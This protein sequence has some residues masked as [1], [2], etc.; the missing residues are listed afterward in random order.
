MDEDEVRKR[1]PNWK[2]P[3]EHLEIYAL[4]SIGRRPDEVRAEFEG[5]FDDI[6]GGGYRITKM[7]YDART[8]SATFIM[9]TETSI[10]Y[11][12][13]SAFISP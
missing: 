7:V 4:N 8:R 9:A 5:F 13:G 12:A 1:F 6:I 2:S 3:L 11:Y 10:G